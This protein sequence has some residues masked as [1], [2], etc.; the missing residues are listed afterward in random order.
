MLA[1][2]I[3]DDL[4]ELGFCP[5]D[6]THDAPEIFPKWVATLRNT[7]AAAVSPSGRIVTVFVDHGDETLFLH[8]FDR[9]GVLMTRPS[10]FG[11]DET[12]IALF[13]AAL[14]VAVTL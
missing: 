1:E 12:G 10:T 7:D 6:E 2:S 9:F 8:I 3:Y 11:T 14:S 13:L 4:A 5:H